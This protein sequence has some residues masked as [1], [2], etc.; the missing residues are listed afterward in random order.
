MEVPVTL[1]DPLR[2]L[3]GF[4]W[5]ENPRLLLCTGLNETAAVRIIYHMITEKRAYGC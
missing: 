5:G 1:R 4:A 3:M 2:R